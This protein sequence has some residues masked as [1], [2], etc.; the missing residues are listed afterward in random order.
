MNSQDLRNLQE[1]YL[2]VVE[3]QQLYEDYIAWDFGP[4]QKA[5]AKYDKLVR[6]KEAGGAPKGTATRANTIKNVAQEMRFTLDKDSLLT[7]INP[8]KQGLQPSTPRHTVAALRGAGGGTTARTQFNV[9]PLNPTRGSMGGGSSAQGLGSAGSPTGRYQVGGGRGYG[10]SGI[11][12]ADSYEY[13]VYDIVLS[14]LLDEGYAETPEAAEALMVNM[15]EE[16]LQSIMEV[17]GGSIRSDVP[18]PGRTNVIRADVPQPGRTGVSI[19][20]NGQQPPG[21]ILAKKAGEAIQ[22]ILGARKPLIS[23]PAPEPRKPLISTRAPEP[24]KPLI[25]T[26]KPGPQNNYGR[27]F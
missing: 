9:E 24:R 25:S 15:S 23:T 22:N 27:G 11:R 17:T 18:Q 2:D 8:R 26:T 16:W 5:K 6:Q 14:H 19:T 20:A 7:G 21:E 3:N 10:L 13:D 4:K 12:L 1:A